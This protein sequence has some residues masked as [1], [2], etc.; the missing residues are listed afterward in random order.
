MF[1]FIAGFSFAQEKQEIP[2][3]SATALVNS[4]SFQDSSFNNSLAGCGFLIQT[5]DDILACTCKH[6]LWV[7][8]TDAMN[9]I[10]FEGSLQSWI[11]HPK[12]DTE[13]TIITDKLLNTNRDEAIGPENVNAD[14]LVFSISRNNSNVTPL[15]IRNEPLIEGEPLF[16]IGWAFKDREGSQRVYPYEYYK[17]V[18]NK[19]LLRNP[20]P[21]TN[22][23]GLSGG[24][25][26]DSQQRLVGIVSDFTADPD[27]GQ[28]FFSPCSTEYLKKVL[29]AAGYHLKN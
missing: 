2:Q 1:L 22:R 19:L 11:M 23:A 20:R 14:W 5:E 16:A 6:A 13:Q 8:K 29:Q 10:H 15:V 24:A 3:F 18:G 21:Q 7:A 12:F 25:I 27:S 26:V 28:M 17:T 9:G 4:V